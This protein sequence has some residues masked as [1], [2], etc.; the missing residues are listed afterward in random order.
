MSRPFHCVACGSKDC[1]CLLTTS[2]SVVLVYPYSEK[3]SK[4][5]SPPYFVRGISP[6]V[7]TIRLN[8]FLK[9]M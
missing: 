6:S 2:G 4:I 9:S 5:L 1:A 8:T 7:L 3:N